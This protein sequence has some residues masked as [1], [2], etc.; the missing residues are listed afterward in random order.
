MKISVAL[1]CYNGEE[2][3]KE[4]LDSILAQTVPVDEIVISDD[5]SRDGT[6]SIISD[7]DDPRI[8]LI[9]GNPKP[10]YCGNFEFVLKHI[11]GDVIFLSDQDDI[12]TPDKVE[13]HL[14]V[15]YS[16]PQI[17]LIISNATLI[18]KSGNVLD[19]ENYDINTQFTPHLCGVHTGKV[20]SS[21]YLGVCTYS[22]LAN[23]MRMCFTKSLLSLILPFPDS[24]VMHDRWIG[25]CGLR[26]DSVYYLDQKL[27]LY[28][29]HDTNTSM[30]GHLSLR[31]RMKKALYGAYHTPY[32]MHNI[33]CCMLAILPENDRRYNGTYADA[34]RIL[35]D[36]AIM[37][38]ALSQN[39]FSGINT[40]LKLHRRSGYYRSFGTKTLIAH[41]CL[42][43]FGR[44]YIKKHPRQLQE[45]R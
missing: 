24:G 40:I 39:P 23:G 20:N 21:D 18:D 26:N 7:Y 42:I 19:K 25:F 27:V 45:R 14:D 44:R 6:V 3:I 5:G 22:S 12:W 41:L 43:L 28:R 34:K 15:L 32:D 29:L 9:T 37:V 31:K 38:H 13:K 10:G 11:T 16:N 4:Q 1:A 33:A 17:E 30:R 2:Y 8:H 36:S 35:D